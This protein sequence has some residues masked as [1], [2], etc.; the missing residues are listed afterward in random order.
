MDLPLDHRVAAAENR[1]EVA[2]ALTEIAELLEA[3]E[4][5]PYRVR[6]YRQAAETI[7]GLNV[8]LVQFLREY[9]IPGLQALPGIG[10]S[11]ARSIERLSRTG[12]LPLLTSLRGKRGDE[13]VLETVPG[14]GAKTAA[15]IHHQLGIVTLPDLEAAA[16]DGR[17]AQVPGMGRKRLRAI[18]DALASRLASRPVRLPLARPPAE[19]SVRRR[20]VSRNRL[21]RA[22]PLPEPSSHTT[23]RRLPL[24]FPVEPE[25]GSLEPTVA[26]LLSLDREYRLKDQSG[27]LVKIAPLR[28]NPEGRAWLSMLHSQRFNR[29]FTVLFSNAPAAHEAGAVGDWVVIYREGPQPGQW[30]VLTERTGPLAGRRV[31]RGWERECAAY[32]AAAESSQA[33]PP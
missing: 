8:P 17:L 31:V 32:Y 24:P 13:A 15:L 9:G 16:C 14:I 29:R 2:N 18:R 7:R 5:N 12:T 6:S 10:E 22:G 33:P 1:T 19:F 11:L 21:H 3:R 27:E 23:E 25:L 30:T 28:F 4:E 20:T 26:E